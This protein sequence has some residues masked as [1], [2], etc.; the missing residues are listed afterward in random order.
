MALSCKREY[1][2]GREGDVRVTTGRCAP[3]TTSPAK[4]TLIP[5]SSH[6]TRLT[7]AA[8]KGFTEFLP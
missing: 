7:P 2:G 8:E 6:G 3:G 1:R 5:R 4:A